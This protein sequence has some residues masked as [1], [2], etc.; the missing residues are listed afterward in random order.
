[1]PVFLD[2]FDDV[3]SWTMY[4]V[5][6][7]KPDEVVAPSRWRTGTSA[8]GRSSAQGAPRRLPSRAQL[9]PATVDGCTTKAPAGTH[10]TAKTQHLGKKFKPDNSNYQG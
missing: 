5:L 9:A 3:D 8:C 2:P 7:S 4:Q 6:E 10:S 1:M